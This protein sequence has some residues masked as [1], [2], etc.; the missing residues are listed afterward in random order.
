MGT[1]KSKR[2]QCFLSKVDDA[3]AARA[4]KALKEHREALRPSD[5][6]DPFPKAAGQFAGIV[7]K[8]MGSGST[9]PVNVVSAPAIKAIEFDRFRTRLME[10]RD[11][12]PHQRGYDFERFLKDLF[13]AFHL[14]A[15]E[16][17]RLLGE[18]ID[19][20]FTLAGETYLLEA[21]WL[22]HK[23]GNA[24]LGSFAAKL[25]QKAAWT[26]GLFISFQG[27]ADQGLHAVGRGQRLVCMDGRDIFTALTE[28][29]AIDRLI[30]LKVRHAAETG[31]IFVPIEK[32]VK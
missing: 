29:M 32:L 19:G 20:S 6:G 23:I 5:Q 1:S 22:N 8:L 26:R 7:A 31:E 24:E 3:T 21:K 16:P 13:D 15:R 18:Q 10:I 4:L 17:Y 27:F 28:G 30:S 2:L 12:P 25:N 11:Q 9:A 14:T